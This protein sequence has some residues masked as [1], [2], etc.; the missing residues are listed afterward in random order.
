MATSG[1]AIAARPKCGGS[2]STWRRPGN[3]GMLAR[4]LAVSC[5]AALMLGGCAAT[6]MKMGKP[7]AVERLS[8]L[9]VGVST[10][11]DVIAVLGE[12]QGRGATRSPTYG[13]KDAWLYESAEVTGSRAHVR[14]LMVFLDKDT[15][16]YQGHMW[17][18]SGM[19][20]G[21]TK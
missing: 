5:V 2:E 9:T 11:K 19:L 14:M 7:P 4:L 15:A 20:F 18:A 8:E 21:Q 1:Q 3:R 10:A 12:P 17:M 16:V 13:L 6:T